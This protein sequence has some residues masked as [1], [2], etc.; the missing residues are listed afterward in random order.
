MVEIINHTENA[1]DL[2]V[3]TKSGR[4]QPGTTFESIKAM[5]LEEKL[6]HLSYMMDT[7]QTSFEFVDVVF[8]IKGVSRALTHQLVRTRTASYQQQAMRVVDARDFEYLLST[9]EPEYKESAD[10]ALEQY[11]KRKYHYVVFDSI[12]EL[13]FDLKLIRR[14][15]IPQ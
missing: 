13:G 6:D 4:L 15:D 3:F 14:I 1:L 5:S 11:G 9:E 7:I 8:L 2:L 10:F 12:E